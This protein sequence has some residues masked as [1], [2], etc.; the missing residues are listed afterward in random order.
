MQTEPE[1][2]QREFTLKETSTHTR[3]S[4][5]AH[6]KRERELR[7]IELEEVARVTRVRLAY[8]DALERERYADLPAD[9]YVRGYLRAYCRFLGV[10]AEPCI[11]QY[12][13]AKQALRPA[14]VVRLADAVTNA[15]QSPSERPLPALA[16]DKADAAPTTTTASMRDAPRSPRRLSLALAI[17]LLVIAALTILFIHQINRPDEAAVDDRN[18]TTTENAT[19]DV[20]G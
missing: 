11:E 16:A 6:L 4:V 17:V 18:P 8:L 20:T 3:L 19:F 1:S 2:S 12:A 13:Q 10:D 7:E 15:P 9:V 5:G 14:P